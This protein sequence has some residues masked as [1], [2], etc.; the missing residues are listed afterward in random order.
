M[1]R[2]Q[3]QNLSFNT[4]LYHTF[5][6]GQIQHFS[7]TTP[8]KYH[9]PHYKWENES[10]RERVLSRLLI[11]EKLGFEHMFIWVQCAPYNHSLLLNH[12]TLA[13]LVPNPWHL[14]NLQDILLM[15]FSLKQFFHLFT[16][17]SRSCSDSLDISGC[18]KTHTPSSNTKSMS[19]SSW[20]ASL[21]GSAV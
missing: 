3:I 18:F 10:S 13:Y 20:R 21:G 14:S 11:C 12:S 16:S 8:L 9:I 6:W 15:S 19:N 17:C 1:T 2:R 7:H 5:F 4:S